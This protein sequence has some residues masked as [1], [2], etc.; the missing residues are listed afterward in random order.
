MANGSNLYK[1]TLIEGIS[2][3]GVFNENKPLSEIEL[4]FSQENI[5]TVH[6]G[7]LKVTTG[8]QGTLRN[9]F[10]DFPVET[11]AK[12]G[13]AEE[14]KNRPSHSWFA[15]FAPYDNPQ[16]AV[17]VLVPFGEGSS[18]PA[19]KTAKDAIFE[20]MGCNMTYDNGGIFENKLAE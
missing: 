20:Y 13:T 11:A 14:N 9:Y 4:G 10:A 6:K 15:G 1:S 7:M 17:V 5:S 2:S 3:K 8:S 16:I 18:A 19:I 12:T